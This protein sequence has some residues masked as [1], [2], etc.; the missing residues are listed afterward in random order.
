[1]LPSDSYLEVEGGRAAVH[2]LLIVNSEGEVCGS[3]VIRVATGLFDADVLC[4]AR[5]RRVQ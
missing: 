2:A 3:A 4:H 1:M 5:L